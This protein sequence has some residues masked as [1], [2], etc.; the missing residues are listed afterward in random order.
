MFNAIYVGSFFET[1]YK[2]GRPFVAYIVAAF[3]AMGAAE[4][5]HHIPGLGAL[6]AFAF[7]HMALQGT[8]LVGGALLFAAMTHPSHRRACGAFERT[9]L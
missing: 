7:D 5:L 4:A 6:N 9:D 8:L 1:S 2:H 3:S